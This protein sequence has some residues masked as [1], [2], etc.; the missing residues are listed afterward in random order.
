MATCPRPIACWGWSRSPGLL[1]PTSALS[2]CL[3]SYLQFTEL[4]LDHQFL[5]CLKRQAFVSTS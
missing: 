3:Q 2:F 5:I 4:C 1:T